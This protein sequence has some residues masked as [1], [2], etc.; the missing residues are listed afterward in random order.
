MSNV[1]VEVST[2]LKLSGV[3]YSLTYSNS[4]PVHS[5]VGTVLC[6][7]VFQQSSRWNIHSVAQTRAVDTLK[8]RGNYMT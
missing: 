2:F 3:T 7:S 8:Q 1:D 6:V 5:A 4:V